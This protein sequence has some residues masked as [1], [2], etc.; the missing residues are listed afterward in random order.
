VLGEIRNE[1]AAQ[2]PKRDA[3]VAALEAELAT[4]RSE[5][6][7][8]ARAVAMAD[9]VPELVS[10]LQ[11]RSALIAHFDA[12]IIAATHPRGACEPHH[13]DR[14]IARARLTDLRS[15]LTDRR[16]LR[17]VFL[18]LFPEGLTFTPARLPDESRQV[19]RVSGSAS[20]SSVVGGNPPV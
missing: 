9:D 8:L 7:R 19:W 11:K 18:A 5:Q 6:K 15:A 3:D 10:E 2:L 4:A 1:I 14:G 12:Q 16:D 17:E 20:F 13:D